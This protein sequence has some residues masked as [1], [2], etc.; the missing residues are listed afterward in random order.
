MHQRQKGEKM[1]PNDPSD[2]KYD[3]ELRDRLKASPIRLIEMPEHV[4]VM[5]GYNRNYISRFMEPTLIYQWKG[6][7]RVVRF[8]GST[9][10]YYL[11]LICCFL[12][13]DVVA[14][15]HE[16]ATIFWC[17]IFSESA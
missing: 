13:I 12:C 16:A 11:F 15:L 17:G 6:M 8:F 3:T 2:D 1:N 14:K 10:F 9:C 4:L 5:F 7:C